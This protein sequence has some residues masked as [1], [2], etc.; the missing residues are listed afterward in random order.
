LNGNYVKALRDAI[1]DEDWDVT[2]IVMYRRI[3]SWLVSWYNQLEKT[4]SLDSD[5][6]V[7]FD[8]NGNPYRTEHTKWPDQGGVHVP[9]FADWYSDFTKYWK[10]IPERL[11]LKHRSIGWYY[12]YKEQFDNV[13]LYNIHERPKGGIVEDFVCNVLE[14]KNSC[15]IY[16]SRE[17]WPEI[18]TNESVNLDL[19]ILSVYAYEKGLIPKSAKRKEVVEAVASH[20][21]ETGKILPRNCDLKTKDEIRFLLVETEKIMVG[22]DNWSD[23]KEAELLEEYKTF[24]EKGKM[25]NVDGEAV[26]ADEEWVSLFQSL[27]D[28]AQ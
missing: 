11:L 7:L 19:D 24:M 2:V 21:K 9:T 4:T 15:S 28:P 6:N 25:C 16:R 22:A 1:N 23:A 20:I 3:H 14:A 18:D 26:L 27:K 13:V 10:A 5:G 17:S 12:L 8:E